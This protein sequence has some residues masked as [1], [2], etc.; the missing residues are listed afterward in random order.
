MM[1]GRRSFTSFCGPMG[2]E[3]RMGLIGREVRSG[4]EIVY[5]IALQKHP[6]WSWNG[7]FGSVAILMFVGYV[8]LVKI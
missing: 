6:P 2:L 4:M 8:I 3:G 1:H 5:L 7:D